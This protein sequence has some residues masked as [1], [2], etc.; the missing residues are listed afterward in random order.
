MLSN[1]ASRF[2]SEP[3]DTQ[4]VRSEKIAIF[5]VAVACSVAGIIWAT[6][7][8][9]VFGGSWIVLGDLARHP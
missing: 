3:A 5:L 7:Y 1:I 6:L 4:E 2:A 8:A 9:V